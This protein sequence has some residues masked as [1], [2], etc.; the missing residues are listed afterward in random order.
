MHARCAGLTLWAISKTYKL[1][2][3][4]ME[5]LLSALQVGIMQSHR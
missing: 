3:E 2:Q 1:P 4:G 5:Q